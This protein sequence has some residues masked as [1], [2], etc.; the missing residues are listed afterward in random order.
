MKY[1]LNM[2]KQCIPLCDALNSIPGFMT[3]ESCCG[4]GKKDFRIWFTS[5]KIKGLYVIARMLDRRYYNYQEWSCRTDGSDNPDLSPTFLLS[6][7]KLRGSKAYFQS[8]KM[9]E[10]IHTFLQDRLLTKIYQIR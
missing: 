7:G 10:A 4:H 2:D 6:S 3:Y 1:G 9:A 8:R 5:V